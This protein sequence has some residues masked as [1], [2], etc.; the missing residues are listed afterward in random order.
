MSPE[1]CF[2]SRVR[3][4]CC[5]AQDYGGGTEE[6]GGGRAPG[7]LQCSLTLGTWH[8][9]ACCLCMP[10]LTLHGRAEGLLSTEGLR[11]LDYSCDLAADRAHEPLVRRCRAC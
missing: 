6:H 11:I 3:P 9:P 7:L 1:R 4:A 2:E 10:L 8:C 5:L